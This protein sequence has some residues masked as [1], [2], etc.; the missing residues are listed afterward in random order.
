MSLPWLVERERW[1]DVVALS[2]AENYMSHQLFFPS[3]F[4]TIKLT[5]TQRDHKSIVATLFPE[6]LEV[7][8]DKLL[9]LI[10]A[11]LLQEVLLQCCPSSLGIPAVIYSVCRVLH[12]LKSQCL[13]NLESNQFNCQMAFPYSYWWIQTDLVF[14]AHG[15]KTSIWKWFETLKYLFITK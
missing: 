14:L 4:N 10:I 1:I 3:V 9:I 11:F 13:L 15:I 2:I 8:S 6:H 12:C 5:F 7:Q